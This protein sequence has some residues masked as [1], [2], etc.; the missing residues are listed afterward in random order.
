MPIARRGEIWMADLGMIAKVRP[1]LILSVGYQDSERAVVTYVVRTT[2]TRGTQYEVTHK[3]RGMKSGAFDAQGVATI[4]D[5]K[6]ERKVGSVDKETLAQVESAV[7]KW[8]AL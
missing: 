8:L 2:S 3:Q 1:V 7:R 4:P 5:I 6:L